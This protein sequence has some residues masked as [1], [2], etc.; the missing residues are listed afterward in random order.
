M[1]FGSPNCILV[2][3][4][5]QGDTRRYRS[6]H[7]YQQLQ[8]AGV[9]CA[10]SHLT[11]PDL[12]A[13]MAEADVVLLHRVP[14]D[15]Y[16][17]G[18]VDKVHRRQG[19]VVMDID[20]LLF[21][22][23]AFDWIDSP[24]FTDPVRAA[25]YREDMDRQRDML[26]AS[27]AVTV[28]TEYLYQRVQ[29]MGRPALVHRNAFSLEMLSMAEVAYIDRRSRQD[30]PASPLAKVVIGYA[31]GTPTHDADFAQAAP[32]LQKVLQRHLGAELW[33][34]GP[35][36]LDAS[37]LP[38]KGRVQRRKPVPWRDLPALLAQF[39]INLAPLVL[40][41]PF[42][43]SKSEIKY[44]EAGLV[45]VP[46]VASR[47]PSY[48]YAIRSGENGFLA[49]TES[50]WSDALERLV[51][52]PAQRQELG[53]QARVHTLSHYH[54]AQRSQE[55]VESLDQLS[56]AARGRCLFDA[57]GRELMAVSRQNALQHPERFWLPVGLELQPTLARRAAYTLRHR[58]PGTLLGLAW[59]FFRRKA[60]PLFPFRPHRPG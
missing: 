38:F 6:F 15:R 46:T 31:S 8:L 43:L 17:Q 55:L 10:L 35:V 30:N 37:W 25:L 29:S 14:L 20:D 54:P 16:V 40:D 28:S 7:P 58:G 19:L 23:T 24:D 18:L 50:E 22:R 3:S 21:D 5:V 26:L 34:V 49:G 27:D 53:E 13:R 59:V 1:P 33:L 47:T 56:L 51:S 36:Q 4:G 44:V 12:P 39:D 45:G 57:A 32:A 60:A 9:P 48:Q 11:A 2:L 42:S 52:S 41:N